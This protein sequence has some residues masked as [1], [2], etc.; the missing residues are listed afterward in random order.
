MDEPIIS[1][2][3]VYLIS[4]LPSVKWLLGSTAI[5][6]F[7]Y[8]CFLTY[9]RWDGLFTKDCMERAFI[10][11]DCGKSDVDKQVFEQ[12][13]KEYTNAVKNVEETRNAIQKYM[14]A[15]LVLATIGCFIPEKGD[16]YK[17]VAAYMIT[18]STLEVTRDEAVDTIRQISAA[19]K[20][21]GLGDEK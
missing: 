14:I 9:V 18:P 19:I 6:I 13:C 20:E 12:A 8:V 2:W 10:K 3:I 1:P 5:A 11:A 4:V 21:G 17:I 15:V 16:M 7:S